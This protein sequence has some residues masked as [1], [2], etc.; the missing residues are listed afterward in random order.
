MTKSMMCNGEEIED[1]I[2]DG[3]KKMLKSVEKPFMKAAER[4]REIGEETDKILLRIIRENSRLSLYEL[5]QEVNWGVGKV[6]GSVKRLLRDG[7]I[8]EEYFVRNGRRVKLVSSIE[9]E[10]SA[11]VFEIPKEAVNRN[12]SWWNEAFVYG[13]DRLTIGVS[14]RAVDEWE[15]RAFLKAKVSV[16]Q[17]EGSFIF[18]LPKKFVDFYALEKT[19]IGIS[20]VKDL[21]LLTMEG[22]MT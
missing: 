12:F 4:R 20:I 17:I 21:V 5:A 10:P 6:D 3:I 1:K 19:I 2:N 7:K 11:N 9:Y 22:R 18:K 13:L 14:G 8:K 16:K 15:E